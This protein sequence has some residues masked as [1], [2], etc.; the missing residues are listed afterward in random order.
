ML[1]GSYARGD[2]SHQSD[3]DMLIL[4]KHKDKT[5]QD[6]ILDASVKIMDTYCVLIGSI[7]YDEREWETKRYYPI[8]LN[9]RREGIE[10]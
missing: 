8:C 9:I 2:F 5:T 10:I 4:V 7:V 6:D 1:F 3:Y